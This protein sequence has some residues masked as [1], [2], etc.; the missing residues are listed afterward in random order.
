MNRKEISAVLV[1]CYH[2]PLLNIIF[3]PDNDD[4]VMYIC[5]CGSW[6]CGREDGSWLCELEGGSWQCG[7]ED[8]SWLC[9]LEGGNNVDLKEECLDFSDPLMVSS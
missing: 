9:E 3:I 4:Q 5:E 6:N 2:F 1:L 7:L 8:G